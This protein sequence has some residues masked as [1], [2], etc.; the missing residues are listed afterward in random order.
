MKDT[1]IHLSFFVGQVAS[2]KVVYFNIEKKINSTE[3]ELI[4]NCTGFNVVPLLLLKSSKNC[5]NL[6]I[7]RRRDRKLYME[8]L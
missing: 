5:N 3:A 6:I 8:N 2:L 4:I 1:Q 7:I